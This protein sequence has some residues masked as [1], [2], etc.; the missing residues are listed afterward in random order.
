MIVGHA[1]KTRRSLHWLLAAVVGCLAV[2]VLDPQARAAWS[3]PAGCV[4]VPPAA[5]AGFFDETVPGQ[6]SKDGVPGLV[7]SVVSGGA[8]VFARGYGLADVERATPFSSSTSLVRI[9][10]ISKLF[11]WTAVMQQVEAGRLD[12]DA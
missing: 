3:A 5:V 10:S 7:A 4:D 9:A 1:P 6:L 12:L 8:S 11:T 2:P